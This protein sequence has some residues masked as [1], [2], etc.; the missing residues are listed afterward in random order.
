MQSSSSKNADLSTS[1]TRVYDLMKQS[2]YHT[3]FSVFLDNM[4]AADPIY[5]EIVDTIHIQ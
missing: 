2:K 1:L 3:K 5:L 4:A